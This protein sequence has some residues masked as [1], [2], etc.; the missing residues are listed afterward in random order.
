MGGI[1]GSVVFGISA[2]IIGRRK[3]FVVKFHSIQ[4][5]LAVYFVG[6]L[7]SG[8]KTTAGIFIFSRFLTG[9]RYLGI[10]QV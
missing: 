2:F 6:V 4:I 3:I 7:L 9:L 5:T 1:V 8:I 10:Y